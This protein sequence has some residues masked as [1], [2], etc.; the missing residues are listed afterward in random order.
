MNEEQETASTASE[1]AS[2]ASAPAVDAD[3]DG[4]AEI[5]GSPS[6]EPIA[7]EEAAADAEEPTEEHVES[8]PE[9]ATSAES[10]V[11][12][13]S[14]DEDD[15]EAAPEDADVAS[16]AE[17]E[18]Q[19]A[20]SDEDGDVEE[21]ELPPLVPVLEAALFA[22]AEAVPL[23]RLT[24]V[25]GAWTKKQIVAALE[26]LAERQERE[27]SGVRVVET[28]GGF[29]LRSVSE[30][31]PWVRKFFTEKPPR[32][33]RAVLETLAIVAYRQPATRGEV[34]AVRGVNCDAVLGA[35]TARGL[36][37]VIGRRVSPGRPVEYGTTPEFLELFSLK[38]LADLPPL[39][40]P[41][42][43]A[44]LAEQAV[45]GEAEPSVD[46][47][48]DDAAPEG[49]EAP[50]LADDGESVAAEREVQDETNGGSDG[51]A[52]EDPEPGGD[53]LEAFGGS[54]DPGGE[55]PGQREGDP[56]AGSE[57]GPQP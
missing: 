12:A 36:I 15:G 28:A 13:A 42:A 18:E 24:R 46:S 39:P 52:A 4:S 22:S 37:Q 23:R 57:G 56:R 47:E 55:S 2:D 50:M 5:E 8:A 14:S 9:D 11:Q 16:A 48:S 27:G 44:N 21:E 49:A 3:A 25:L 1:S 34:E 29:Q 35:L 40:D 10:D 33:S 20:S 17:S 45:E 19:A 38:D 26:E 32:L 7:T 43:L 53:R 6:D 41:T 51:E 54:P 30:Y 31:A